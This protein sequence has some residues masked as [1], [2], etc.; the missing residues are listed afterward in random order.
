MAKTFLCLSILFFYSDHK[1]LS[2]QQKR[3]SSTRKVRQC[4]KYL[5]VHFVG[6]PKITNVHDNFYLAPYDNI[7]PGP[8]CK[9]IVK[10]FIILNKQIKYAHTT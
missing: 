1:V 3:G 9:F 2:D 7:D 5:P 6:K 10:M 8:L 4:N